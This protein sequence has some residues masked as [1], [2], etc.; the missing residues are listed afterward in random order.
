[1]AKHYGDALFERSAPGWGQLPDETLPEIAVVGR[2]NVGKSSLVNA[3]LRRKALAR[4]SATPGK[5]REFNFYRIDDEFYL[6]DVPGFGYAKVARSERERWT[7]LI[8]KYV[9]ERKALKLVL[10]LVDSRHE[11]TALDREVMALMHES[12]AAYVILLTKSDKISGNLREK[13]R[14]L[15]AAAAAEAG[16]EVPVVL[17]SAE[18]GRGLDEVR[19]WIFT[20]TRS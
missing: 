1:M 11:P 9:V 8:G 20:H 15:A 19:S 16:L 3:V 6:V 18:D 4:T 13:H 17:T 10:H 7:K 14:R 5:T 12:K 2:S